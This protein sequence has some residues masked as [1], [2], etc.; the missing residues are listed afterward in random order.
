[1]M[2]VNSYDFLGVLQTLAYCAG[3]CDG[4]LKGLNSE[5]AKRSVALVETWV[6]DKARL[7]RQRA[8]FETELGIRYDR[9]RKTWYAE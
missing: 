2:Q 9:D 5:S 4:L 3:E 1:M 8:A 7:P 6:D